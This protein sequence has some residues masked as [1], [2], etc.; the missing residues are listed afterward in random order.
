MTKN[1][2]FDALPIVIRR[3]G[4]RDDGPTVALKNDAWS[5]A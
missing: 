2:L 3:T 4:L 1:I 5:V